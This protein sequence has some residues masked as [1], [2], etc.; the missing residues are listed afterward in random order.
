MASGAKLVLK[1]RPANANSFI[2]TIIDGFDD[3]GYDVSGNPGAFSATACLLHDNVGFSSSLT[4]GNT[5]GDPDFVPFDPDY[6]IGS[7]SAGIGI[8]LPITTW[9]S[10]DYDYTI[11]GS[12]FDIGAQENVP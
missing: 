2:N 3:D 6:K 5:I 9:G 7:D 10:N 11:R 4:S 8:G 12:A 1:N